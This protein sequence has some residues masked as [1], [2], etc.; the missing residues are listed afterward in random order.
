[1][2]AFE[3]CPEGTESTWQQRLSGADIETMVRK[4][5]AGLGAHGAKNPFFVSWERL[6]SVITYNL[7]WIE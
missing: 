5:G 2:R 6:E 4:D 3:R 1:V 7:N